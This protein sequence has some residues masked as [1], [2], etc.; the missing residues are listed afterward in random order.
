M[1]TL[2]SGRQKASSGGASLRY[3]DRKFHKNFVG[4][5]KSSLERQYNDQS[6][7]L[8]L[9]AQMEDTLQKKHKH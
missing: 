4:N 9:K 3:Y 5:V 7:H 8:K 6:D 2:R 1:S